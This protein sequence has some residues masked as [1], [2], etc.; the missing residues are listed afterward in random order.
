MR[1]LNPLKFGAVLSLTVGINYALCAIFWA[2]WT[3]RAIDFLNALFHGLDFRHMQAAGGFNLTGF[4]YALIVL[5][6]WAYVVGVVFALVRNWVN[7]D[8]ST[9]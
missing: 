6:V 8:A 5:L 4:V 2:L 9:P 1:R 3:D 7:P